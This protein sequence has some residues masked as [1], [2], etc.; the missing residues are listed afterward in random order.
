MRLIQ[1]RKDCLSPVL[2]VI[3]IEEDGSEAIATSLL[4]VGLTVH[5]S[6]VVMG[7]TVHYSAVV[8]G[9]TLLPAGGPSCGHSTGLSQRS[10]CGRC[11]PAVGRKGVESRVMCPYMVI[12]NQE[13]RVGDVGLP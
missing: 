3:Q 9:L 4:G 13:V 12:M 1:D 7:L 8:M 6:A 2:H 11:R 5:Y 10:P